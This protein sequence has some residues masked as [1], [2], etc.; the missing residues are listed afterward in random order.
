MDYN[1]NFQQQYSRLN[2]Q[3]KQAVDQIEGPV[4]VIAGAGTGKTQT[5]ALRIANI[6]QQGQAPPSSIL[7]LSFTESAVNNMR[8]RLLSVIGPSA[9]QV[10][11]Y[12]FHSFCQT[13]I[14]HHLDRFS[15]AKEMIA[16]DQVEK[17]KIIDQIIDDLPIDSPLKPWGDN[18][19][20]QR[21]IISNIQQLKREDISPSD[22]DQL[23]SSQTK[24]IESAMSFYPQL[25]S[26]RLN[27]D[28]ES[29]LLKVVDSLLHI[30]PTS[31]LHRQID[32]YLNLYRQGF[33]QKGDCSKCSAKNQTINFKN[34]LID[35]LDKLQK[36]QPKQLEF[37]QIY[38]QYQPQ[39]KQQ[40]FYD[41]EDMIT[42]V[43]KE[44]EKDADF[45]AEYQE[46]I[47][48]IL[49]DEY[50]DTNASQNK[51]VEMISSYFDRPNLF[52][53]GDDDQS[54]F[55][56]QGASLE[57]L[58]HFYHQ[59]RPEVVVLTNNYR[60]H[61]LILDSSK[62]VIQN[63]QNRISQH[64]KQ[65]DKSLVSQKD[66]DSTPINLYT[67]S[68]PLDEDYFI[69]NKIKQLIKN[70]VDP[71]QIA[72]FYRNNKDANDL[73][74]LLN[75]AGIKHHLSL[76]TNIL[77]NSHIN[78]LI[79]LL[80]Y[81]SQPQHDYLLARLLNFDFF[82]FNQVDLLKI[83]SFSRHQSIS[84]FSLISDPDQ[85]DQIQ[86]SLKKSTLSKLKRLVKHL[87]WAQKQQH[88]LNLD[89]F[90]IKFLH[91]FSITKYLLAQ[92][93]HFNL[94][95]QLNAFYQ[96]LKIELAKNDRLDLKSFLS[97]LQQYID[98]DIAIPFADYSEDSSLVQLMTVHKA[99]G[100]EFEHVFLYKCLDKVWSNPRKTNYLPLPSG[101]IKT[102]IAQFS[103]D[104]NEEERR[105]FYVA[106]TRA[107]KQIYISYSLHS[108]QDKDQSPAQFI[109]E[110]DS[111]LIEQ[112]KT[113]TKPL[114]QSLSL[115]FSPPSSPLDQST[116]SY[117][118]NYL[119]QHYCLTIT[120]LNS[121]LNCP[122]CFYL[123]NIL[124]I[125]MKKN[126]SAS[127]GTAIHQA[128]ASL[129]QQ[130]QQKIS[131]ILDIFNQTLDKQGLSGKDH[132]SAS[133]QGQAILSAY[134]QHYQPQIKPAKWLEYDFRSENLHLDQV[135][136][137]GKIDKI[138]V[139][140]TKTAGSSDI[141]V[142][143][144]KTGNPQNSSSKADY[145]RQLIFYKILIDQSY[146]FKNYHFKSAMIDYV[147]AKT[148]GS[149]R[150]WI[151]DID[152]Q[153]VEDLKKLIQQTYQKILNLDFFSFGSQCK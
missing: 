33:Y 93:D 108:T 147:K 95:S 34:V 59:Y 11:I 31:P 35:F 101:L 117:L 21:S 143:D 32:Y 148:D 2:P 128:L 132:Q 75:Q 36:N 50:Q 39:I 37:A 73:S 7:S 144:F 16:I 129:Y 109:S 61:Q 58:L 54:I 111:H 94:L 152:D 119:S 46:T 84:L 70:S 65:V 27:K 86:P 24:F 91:K 107:K 22:L 43:V 8:Q 13:I 106:L 145:F 98:N 15:F 96:F 77:K 113:N 90:F 78:H 29:Q 120:H 118:K 89:S 138:E 69:V 85:L 121:Y 23:L 49:V 57:N 38:K 112:I 53:V 44:F 127:M 9:Y 136:I 151:V 19:F 114:S 100:L 17:I 137:T 68:S 123:K 105:L 104:S 133:Q 79:Q 130:P 1:Q 102:E 82:K 149:F 134:Y 66:Y 48:Y 60:S 51:I 80:N 28:I 56:F 63:N 55:R 10:K 12:T 110:I 116:Q 52:V 25:K 83:F 126:K 18:Y 67:A 131:T 4:M 30:D 150:Q 124:R 45:L 99:K 40:G 64:I 20:Y 122:F 141:V 140:D 81:I 6:L 5:L 115:L 26:L 153:Q 142:T 62:S 41:F 47:H 42:L 88:N 14:N 92:P 87:A 76:P 71:S 146:T 3:Q 103:A 72:V 139:L 125:P 97:Q 74:F 135:P